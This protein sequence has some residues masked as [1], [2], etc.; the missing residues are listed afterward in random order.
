MT[1]AELAVFE[2]D[3]IVIC[4]EQQRLHWRDD[5]YRACVFIESKYF[6]K[7]DSPMT[8]RPEFLT[9]SY[10][11]DYA[12]RHK[13]GPRISQ[14]LHYFEAQSHGFGYFVMEYI[15][16]S[17]SSLVTNLAGRAAFAVNW[18]SGVPAPPED[19]TSD[20]KNVIGPTGA[21]SFVI[22][23][24]RTIEPLWFFRASMP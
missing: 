24:S 22:G 2:A 9:Q 21:V 11:Y 20:S 5:G 4:A 7:F 6:I 1:D 10:I 23:S 18:L 12:M 3:I 17:Q 16:L 14:P 13:S 19:E 15:E 8:L